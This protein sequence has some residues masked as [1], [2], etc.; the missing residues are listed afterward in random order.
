MGFVNSVVI[1]S[2]LGSTRI[3]NKAIRLINGKPLI[4]HLV[5]RLFDGMHTQTEWNICLAVPESELDEYHKAL[6]EFAAHVKFFTGYDNDPLKRMY[7]AAKFA[8]SN[9]V[10]RITHD[11]IFINPE[12]IRKCFS[13]IENKVSDYVYSSHLTDGMGFECFSFDLLE[14]ASEKFNGVEHISYPLRMLATKI[15]NFLPESYFITDHRLLID[16]PIDLTLMEVILA[17]L[18]N[19]PSLSSVISFLDQNP[20]IAKT[21]RLPKVTVYTVARNCDK[22]IDETMRSVAVQDVFHQC[23]Y[24]LI[25]DYSDDRTFF[26]MVKFANK[27]E[28]VRIVRNSKN[29]GLS[30]SC[31]IALDQARGKYIIRMDGDDYFTT[32]ESLSE[33]LLKMEKDH[34]SLDVLYP[35]NFFGSLYKI[36]KGNEN[37]HA[38]GALFRTRSLNYLRFTD[39]LSGHDSLDIY[40]RAKDVL[41]IDYFEKPIF[42]YRQHDSSMTKN[43]LEQREI[44]KQ[45][46]INTYGNN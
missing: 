39:G 13:L 38:G 10:C 2:R 34:R 8:G 35:D 5:K 36:Q 3:K 37:H 28:N 26:K 15:K 21:N 31:N 22:F 27:F 18:G 20:D 1:C 12:H 25:D 7:C 19:F 16:Y 6:G 9:A 42:F 11:K 43:D 29:I 23:E 46:L 33:M 44:L 17:T 32:S 30:T 24:L 45:H 41:A 14:K 40:L 4:Y